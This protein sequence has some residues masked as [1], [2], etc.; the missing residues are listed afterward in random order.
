MN[1]EDQ[2]RAYVIDH[3]KLWGVKFLYNKDIGMFNKF[4]KI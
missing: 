3:N 2:V 1:L 4:I